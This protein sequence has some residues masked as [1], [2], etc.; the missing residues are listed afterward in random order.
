M[1]DAEQLTLFLED[2]LVSHSPLQESEKVQKTREIFGKKCLGSFAK[3]D[4]DGSW[5]KTYQ[6]CCQY[7]MDGSLEK[8]LET[9][10]RSGFVWSGIAYQLQPLVPI[11]KEI[12][13]GYWATPTVVD[14]TGRTYGY[15]N[16]KK[17][18]YLPGQVKIWRTPTAT[19]GQRGVKK[20]MKHMETGNMYDEKGRRI[21]ITL[22]AQART[23]PTPRIG[24][25]QSS[26]QSGVEHGD[27]AAV[28]GGTLNP[29]WVEWLMGLPQGWTDLNCLE[30]AKSFR[31]SNGSA[32]E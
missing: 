2:S 29:Q 20:T 16:G 17:V 25:S 19:D 3:L 23:W 13:S 18:R 15:S 8:W 7:L 14:S 12:E 4:R 11:T 5:L 22:D 1:K 32:K 9:W 10:P 28:V 6:G 26:S 24:G 30:T 31:L 27:L 21:Q